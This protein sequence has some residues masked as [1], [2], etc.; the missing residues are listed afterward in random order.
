MLADLVE[1]VGGER[2]R[3]TGLMGPGIDPHLYRA[4]AGDVRTLASARLIF[5]VGL[6]LEAAMGEVLQ[7]M[8]R[9]VRT[10]PVAER[11]PSH[12]LLPAAA[13]YPGQHDPHLWFDVS[14]WA[15]VVPVIVEELSALDPGGTEE[16]QERGARLEEE[17]LE[18]H[19]WVEERIRGLPPERR[20]LVTAH[21]AFH[22][23]GRAY[24]VEVRGLQGISTV[25]E[26]SAADVQSLATF[27]V[28][29]DIPAVFVESSVPRRTLEAVRAAVRARGG[30]VAIGGELYS[31]AMGPA[32]TPAAT[33]S[34]MV[35]HNV[36]TFVRAMAGE[37]AL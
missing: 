16:F 9:R 26:P 25:A 7:E 14:L 30:E 21:D 28:E 32:G 8:G 11:I 1:R 35:R 5:Y 17:L 13:D 3:V 24:G 36:E 31:D 6:H 23:F 29:R 15:R 2:V 22:Y 12:L 34:G 33:Y 20:V 37:G 18:L 10:V 27:L 19:A 4:T